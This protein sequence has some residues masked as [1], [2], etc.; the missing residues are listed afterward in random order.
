LSGGSIKVK[1]T[2]KALV[3]KKNGQSVLQYNYAHLDPPS[4]ANMES[5]ILRLVWCTT[6]N[7]MNELWNIGDKQ[8]TVRARSVESI[9]EGAIFSGFTALLDLRS[10]KKQK[11]ETP[12][13]P[14]LYVENTVS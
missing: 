13:K 7:I 14:T 1:D 2:Q 3:L 6:V 5:G 12:T 10:Y 11:L 4:G 8:G 9:Y